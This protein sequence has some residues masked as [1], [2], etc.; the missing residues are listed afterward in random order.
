MNAYTLKIEGVSCGHC[1]KAIKSALHSI[2]G[3]TTEEVTPGY[4]RL[5]GSPLQLNAV[6]KAIRD[7]GYAVIT[8]PRYDQSDRADGG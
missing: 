2:Q 6:T 3:V 8:V 4:A 7:E 1:A 5:Q